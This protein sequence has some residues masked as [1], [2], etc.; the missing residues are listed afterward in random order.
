VPT[1]C[2][3]QD[4]SNSTEIEP[5]LSLVNAGSANHASMLTQS[6]HFE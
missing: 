5:M 6:A 3:R 1:N 2:T 4:A